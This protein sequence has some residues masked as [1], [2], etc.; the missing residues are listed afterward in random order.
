[1]STASALTTSARLDWLSGK[2]ARVPRPLLSFVCQG[3]VSGVS[4]LSSLAVL[5]W[6]GRDDY[7]AYVLFVNAYVLLSS[8]QN[9]VL[10]SPLV[11]LSGRMSVLAREQA[12][13][14]G[15][16]LA[17]LLALPGGLALMA[18]WHWQAQTA[19]PGWLW[20]AV[21]ASFALLLFRDLRRAIWLL[22]GDLLALL[23][24]DSAYFLL[25]T[26]ILLLAYAWHGM[27]LGL[28]IAAVGLPGLWALLAR[29]RFAEHVQDPEFATLDRA[30]RQELWACARWA[31]PGIAVTWL[32][33]NGYWF[34][35]DAVQGKAAVALL[36]ATRLFYTPVGLMI[37]GWAGY[38][39]PVFA[40]MEQAGQQGEKWRLVWQQ[41]IWAA[42]LVTLF[43]A[44]LALASWWLPR[45]VPHF[46]APR[47]WQ[48]SVALWAA[49]FIIQWGRTVIATA[50]LAN[51]VGYRVVFQGG[52]AGCVLF[53]VLF[54]PIAAFTAQ[55]LYCPL[56]LIV[57]EAAIAAWLWKKRHV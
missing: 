9:A 42:A 2:L 13:A 56:A 14:W 23:R 49:Y 18:Y 7:S 4:F 47:L 8:I 15:I 34:Y 50:L 12:V 6:A 38:Y 16:R 40:R 20:L 57:A 35:L 17:L 10:L 53:Y 3:L 48:M 43:A 24:L 37:Q 46:I 21:P 28:A 45:L 30:F 5:H 25:S 29:P 22:L 1:M 52:L 54:L 26:L 55:P 36:A 19:M 44:V 33:S 11:T 31:L 41:L 51:P 39:R 27:S 32:F